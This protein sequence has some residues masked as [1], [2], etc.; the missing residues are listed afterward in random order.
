[1]AHKQAEGRMLYE[2]EEFYLREA[3]PTER[4]ELRR[5][6]KQNLDR[7]W[8]LAE[9]AVT[10]VAIDKKLGVLAGGIEIDMENAKDHLA[11]PAGFVVKPE[12]R[13]KGIGRKLVE[14]ADREIE[15]NG[16]EK[17][18]AIVS[19]E[20]AWKIYRA[21]GYDYPEE[22]KAKLRSDG[23]P[24]DRFVRTLPM[25]KEFKKPLSEVLGGKQLTII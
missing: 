13:K 5:L 20:G 2:D 12:F 15:R 23:L 7:G 22:T 1:M 10:I 4:G 18:T 21:Q 24:L 3:K 25:V 16:I 8:V 11:N 14:A 19:S 9:K 6:F 17:A